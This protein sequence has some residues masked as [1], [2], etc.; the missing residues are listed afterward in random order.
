MQILCFGEQKNDE[1]KREDEGLSRMKHVP[2]SASHREELLSELQGQWTRFPVADRSTV[3]GSYRHD[4]HAGVREEAF[5][6][7]E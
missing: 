3:D 6:G 7:L 5:V 4:F 1:R 2:V